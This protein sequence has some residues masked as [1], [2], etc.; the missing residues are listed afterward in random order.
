MSQETRR[1]YSDEFKA[2][3]VKLLEQEGY[4]LTEA[5]RRL[6]VDRSCLTRWRRELRGE[7]A[8]EPVP[9]SA[10]EKD[11]ELR[12]LREEVRK[13]RMERDIL[14]KAT[15]FFANESN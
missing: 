2:D 8:A 15:A 4:G 9:A 1:R 13:L 12:R 7:K 14:K 3:A 5:A 11:A 10:D 6:G